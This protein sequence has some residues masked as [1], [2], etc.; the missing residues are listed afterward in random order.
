MD[1]DKCINMIRNKPINLW[2]FKKEIAAA[3]EN[4]P[5][6]CLG[7]IKKTQEVAPPS[8]ERPQPL[9][10]RPAHFNLRYRTL[11]E[12]APSSNMSSCHNTHT[13]ELNLSR[14]RNRPDEHRIDPEIN[15]FN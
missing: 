7:M 10:C 4:A 9:S 13:T 11:T 2:P 14:Q 3:V 5:M 12:S 1:G 15:Y 6:W 8:A